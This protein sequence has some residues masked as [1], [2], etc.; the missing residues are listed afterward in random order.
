MHC[1]P[2]D[3]GTTLIFSIGNVLTG[4]YQKTVECAAKHNKPCMHIHPGTILPHRSSGI[5][6][7]ITRSRHEELLDLAER[8]TS[9][10]RVP[11][12]CHFNNL[13]VVNNLRFSCFL[14]ALEAPFHSR[15]PAPDDVFGRKDFLPVE[16]QDGLSF[17]FR[18]SEPR[19]A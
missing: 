10:E 17:L 8:T 7:P 6:S 16:P 12:Y 18:L 19:F 3:T 15:I 4:A 11:G 1:A 14:V 13:L 9:P 2:A 5:L